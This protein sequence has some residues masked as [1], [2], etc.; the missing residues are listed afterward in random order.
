MSASNINVDTNAVTQ[1]GVDMGMA[2]NTINDALGHVAAVSQPVTV[3]TFGEPHLTMV[4]Q[5]FW[6]GLSQQVQLSA[7]VFGELGKR[8]GRG[9]VHLKYSDNKS[10]NGLNGVSNNTPTPGPTAAP[11]PST[12]APAAGGDN[13]PPPVSS[14][15]PPATPTTPT[16]PG[17]GNTPPGGG[18]SNPGSAT[19]V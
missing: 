1:A 13:N 10:A 15:P 19:G 8:M 17:S 5:D 9:A 18:I 3:V 4:F 12:P 2:S 14:A 7:N 11:A 16:E 6:T